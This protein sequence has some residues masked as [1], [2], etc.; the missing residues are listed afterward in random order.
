VP[1]SY[2]CL[3]LTLRRSSNS[4]NNF[5][6]G[7]EAWEVGMVGRMGGKH[8]EGGSGNGKSGAKGNM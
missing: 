5:R 6:G 3:L 7:E 2:Y 1:S 8:M 4:F